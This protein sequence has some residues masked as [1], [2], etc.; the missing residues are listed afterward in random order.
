MDYLNRDSKQLGM[1]YEIRDFELLM[2]EA[3]V[4]DNKICYPTKY[5]DNLL[6]IYDTRH[7][8]YR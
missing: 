3:R 8:L 4:I 1:A 2:K 5:A 6:R 7:K